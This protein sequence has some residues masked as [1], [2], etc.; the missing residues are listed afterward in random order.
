M[1][2]PPPTCLKTSQKVAAKVHNAAMAA[3]GNV[4]ETIVQSVRKTEKAKDGE[5]LDVCVT[6]DGTWH[7]RAHT[8]D[9]GVGVAIKVIS[10]LVLDY[11]VHSN[12][13][14]LCT[15]GPKPGIEWYMEWMEDPR[16]N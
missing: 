7:K 11:T 14:Q 9:F 15:Q 8:S 12:Y 6:Y 5:R 13:C 1:N 4:M 3:A 16:P 2:M 10:G